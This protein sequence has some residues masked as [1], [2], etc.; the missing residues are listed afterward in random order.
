MQVNAVTGAGDA[1]LKSNKG[2]NA[3]PLAKEVDMKWMFVI[4]IAGI[5]FSCSSNHKE[6]DQHDHTDSTGKNGYNMLF[7]IDPAAPAEGQATKLLLKPVKAGTDSTVALEIQH[8]KKIHLIIVSEDLSSFRHLHPAELPD[9]SYTL[10]DTFQHGGNYILYADYK[11]NATDKQVT[12]QTIKVSGKEKVPAVY[13]QRRLQSKANGYTVELKPADTSITS[14]KEVMMT[15]EIHD[16]SGLITPDKLENYLGEKAHMVIIGVS[17]KKYLHV[18]PMLM[19]NELMLHTTFPEAG[20]Y[21]AW[22]EFK[23]DGKV[24]VADFVIKVY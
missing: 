6:K 17:N 14:N 2:K 19:G 3:R 22:L 15:A 18:H 23:K 4:A 12:M 24:N 21:R 7:E 13:E 1:A 8:E 9:G 20:I 16:A 11:P 10:T 5:F